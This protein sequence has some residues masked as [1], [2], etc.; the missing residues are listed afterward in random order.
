MKS[1]TYNYQRE[2]LI[3]LASSVLDIDTGRML[4]YRHPRRDPKYKK[5]WNIFAANGFGRLAQG[6][7]SRL[8]VTDTIYFAHKRDVPQEILKDITY[9]K[10]VCDVCPTKADP[11][12]TI[13]TVWGEGINYPGDCGTPTYD[14]LLV[15][16]LVNSVISTIGG[17]FMTGDI[18]NFYLDT[19]LKRYEYLRPV[20]GRHT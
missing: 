15:K 7:G 2:P 9:K 17:K 4:E 20:I 1:R 10:N 8:K 16:M 6:L 14:M 3:L 13:L 5:S 12:R 18:N 19:T 11:N